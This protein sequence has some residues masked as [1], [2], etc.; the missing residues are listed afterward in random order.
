VTKKSSGNWAEIAE[1]ATAAEALYVAMRRVRN[2]P[3]DSAEPLSVA[4]MT[5]IEPLLD[6]CELPVG[7]LAIR[8]DVSVPTATRMLKSLE[9]RGL[10]ERHRSGEDDRR[11]LVRL[12][13]SGAEVATL[14]RDRIRRRQVS[15]LSQLGATERAVMARQ[16]KKLT[17]MI[18][19][20]EDL[21]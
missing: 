1:L 10:V 11:V 4:Q 14:R 20:P 6:D 3:D 9:A 12:T 8:A 7:Q 15:R 18:N 2:T 19:A 16:L 21:E 13:V 5:L 17:A